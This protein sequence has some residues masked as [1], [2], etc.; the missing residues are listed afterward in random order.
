VVQQALLLMQLFDTVQA[1][2]PPGHTHEPPGLEQ[3]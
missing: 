1:R 3:V 2:W